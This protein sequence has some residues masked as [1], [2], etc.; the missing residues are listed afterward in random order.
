[1]K[2]KSVAEGCFR[3]SLLAKAVSP[4]IATTIL[5]AVAIAIAGIAYVWT[6][7]YTT[8]ITKQVTEQTG[9]EIIESL[10][11]SQLLVIKSASSNG[12][13]I[14]SN[15]SS[16]DI[17]LDRVTVDGNVIYLSPVTI[18]AGG[19]VDGNVI[20][21]SPVT[22]PAGGIAI[23]DLN[24]TLRPGMTIGLIT[25]TGITIEIT[26]TEEQMPQLITGG[27][28]QSIIFR[29]LLDDTNHINI[30]QTTANIAGSEA[31][32]GSTAAPGAADWNVLGD[33]N[34]SRN[35]P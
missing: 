11:I 23:I 13:I 10:V 3:Q 35:L 20:Y 32:L 1:M 8:T 14:V 28:E 17:T 12:R 6:S 18:P 31:T 27:I 4:M 5:I 33:L 30:S 29:D 16:T 2:S 34:V 22:I 26:L 24:M 19:I 15:N 7:S 25:S 21:L 9:P